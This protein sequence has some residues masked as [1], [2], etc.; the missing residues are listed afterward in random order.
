M[1][2]SSKSYN[3]SFIE[4]IGFPVRIN[5]TNALTFISDWNFFKTSSKVSLSVVG[6]TFTLMQFFFYT[7]TL[8]QSILGLL[9]SLF[10]FQELN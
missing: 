7:D 8:Q 6:T 3:Y 2:K 10:Q 5:A 9:V 1:S 4:G